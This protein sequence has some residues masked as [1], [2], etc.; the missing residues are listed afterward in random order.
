MHLRACNFFGHASAFMCSHLSRFQ[1]AESVQQ[2]ERT[3][4]RIVA[5]GREL[6]GYLQASLQGVSLD[7]QIL[8]AC[9]GNGV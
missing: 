6:F 2:A 5:A 7:R 9:S 1:H 4:K 3:A 8:P